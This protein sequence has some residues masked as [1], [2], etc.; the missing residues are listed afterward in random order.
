M[1]KE[2]VTRRL[3][4]ELARDVPLGS[5]LLRATASRSP[6]FTRQTR[7][8][9]CEALRFQSG[10]QWL[11]HESRIR[12]SKLIDEKKR[13]VP[14]LGGIDHK[15]FAFERISLLP[16]LRTVGHQLYAASRFG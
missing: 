5:A 4:A 7:A 13:R 15:S 8:E 9:I 11:S 10:K 1:P 12:L 2:S 3:G 16:A 6:N 14:D